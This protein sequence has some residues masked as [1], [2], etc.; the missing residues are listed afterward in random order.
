MTLCTNKKNTFI[1]KLYP[2]RINKILL[3][4]IKDGRDNMKKI[5]FSPYS[6]KNLPLTQ[7]V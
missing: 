7:H 6:K 5:C 3:V 1:C 4:G 2:L